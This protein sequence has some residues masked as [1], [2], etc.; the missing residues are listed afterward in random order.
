MAR[1]PKNAYIF[2]P[3]KTPRNHFGCLFFLAL[4][5]AVA[6]LAMVVI[7][8]VNNSQIALETQKVT[9][10]GLERN[11]ESTAIL[12]LSDLHGATF[13]ENALSQA[14]GE[15]SY[16]AV[17]VTGDM[18]G[19]SGDY[20]PFL[21][22]LSQLRE[23]VPVLFI[24][25][26]SDPTPILSTAHGSACVYADWVQAA[27]DAGAI[28]LDAPYAL[29]I[30]GRTLW[31]CPESQYSLD[32]PSARA[33]YQAQWQQLIAQGQQN[34]PDGGAA[35]RA[36]QYRLASLDRLESAQKA[37]KADDLQVVVSHQPVTRQ[38]MDALAD[39]TKDSVMA[40]RQADLALAGHY[41]AGQWKLPFG[42]SALYIPGLG[43]LPE[44]SLY[45]GMAWLGSLPQHISPGLGA[46]D[47]YTLQPGRIFNK[48]AVTLITLTGKAS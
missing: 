8:M 32:I 18:V 41:C 13:K 48:P 12:H 27:I 24:A 25:G 43:W 46:S 7:S 23:G 5:I 16:Q 11:L 47:F 35:I 28:Y 20:D 2:A 15:K 26:D 42:G 3:E 9:I 37:M 36:L 45:T 34:T 30:G 17:V 44:K 29:E 31:F 21:S 40:L 6:V 4:F 10:W 33:G 38:D 1:R 39:Y 22:L 19:R 14:L